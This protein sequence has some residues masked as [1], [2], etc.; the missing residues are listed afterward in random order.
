MKSSLL[1]LALLLALP[2]L[3]LACPICFQAEE[4]AVTDGIRAAVVVL[5]GVTTGVLSGFGWFIAGFIRRSRRL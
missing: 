2:G 5:V 4:S 3:A 1:T